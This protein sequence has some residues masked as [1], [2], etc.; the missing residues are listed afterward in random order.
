M[1]VQQLAPVVG[2]TDLAALLAGMR[3]RATLRPFTAEVLEFCTAFSQA[4]FKDPEARRFPELQALAFR[5][6]KAELVRLKREFDRLETKEVLL[7]PRGL[8]FHLPPTNVDTFF[9]YS[10]LMA[11]V[12]GNTNVIRL[13]TRAPQQTG[14]ICRVFRETQSAGGA[15]AGNTAIIQYGH[16]R[17][18]TA[19]VS[20]ACDVRIIWGGDA[21]VEAV[22]SVPLP[23]HAK[24]LTF[25]D[26]Y[27]FAVVNAAA[28][29]ALDAVARGSLA[30]AFFND[31]YWFG[32]MACSSPRLVVWCGPAEE[33]SASAG[34][35]WEHLQEQLAKKGYEIET[36]ARIEQFTFACRAVLDQ[37]VSTYQRMG[38]GLTLLRVE[39][40]DGVTREHPGGGV[41]F[42]YSAGSLEEVAGFVQRR[43]QT[44]CTFGY[45]QEELR[46]F[47]RLVNG[48]G[49]DRI[50]PFGQALNFD[51]RWDGYDLL[52]ELTR[53]VYIGG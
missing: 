49:V 15:V 20:A 42:Q 29:L 24:E 18:I 48:R 16:E 31:T 44:V 52:Q 43:D 45:T 19:A 2:E 33:C 13:S 12:T 46:A 39:R 11:V 32:Q 47:A 41:L 21:S 36:G 22:R 5:M 26:R 8:V 10:W 17:E 6:R 34:A 35:F 38:D 50:V 51:Y 9:V 27:S 7:A 25:A 28:Y 4:L 1:T 53:H 37:G 40:L 14:I 3:S 30:E 23:P